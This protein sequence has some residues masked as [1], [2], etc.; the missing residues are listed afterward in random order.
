VTPKRIII[1]G[2]GA[3]GLAAAIE[4]AH[5][6][7]EVRVLE[8]AS[9]PGGKMRRVNCANR[10]VDAGPTVFTMRWVFDDLLE[11]AGGQLADALPI[12]AATNLARHFWMDGSQLDLHQDVERNIAAVALFADTENADGFSRFQRQAAKH[13]RVLK[14]SFMTAQ[15][16]N[17]LS[18]AANVGWRNLPALLSTRPD[19][20]LWSALGT[21]F[22]DARLRQLYGRYATYVGSSPFD[23]PATLMLIAHVEQ[24][25][26]WQLKGGM[27]S[28]AQTLADTG[29][30]LG[31]QFR[32][33][34]S[35]ATINSQ[36]KRVTGVTLGSGET[37]AA[38]AVVFN[39]DVNALAAGALG[40]DV[41]H[42]FKPRPFGK[43]GLS[44]VT[45]CM[46]AE[47][48]G[49]DLAYHNVFFSDAYEDEFKAIFTDGQLPEQ[50][51]VYICAQDR[52]NG[53][54][55]SGPE[56]LLILINA[57]A[58]ADPLTWD[59][60]VIARAWTQTQRVLAHCGLSI[61][62]VSGSEIATTPADFDGLFPHS[63]G[64]LYGS[65]S[66]GPWSSFTRAGARTQM[67][68][69]YLAGGTVH[70]GPGVP[71]AALSGKLAAQALQADL[72]A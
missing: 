13:Y 72:Y 45:W 35:V 36:Q 46:L 63:D 32:Y 60:A 69:L 39:G 34:T 54:I 17:P 21:Y 53:A 51:T 68:G 15:K 3:G 65:A 22:S 57:P 18:L 70:P 6:G 19:Q 43:R 4:L 11:R 14:D 20:T 61:N 10:G 1:I 27:Q 16:P 55:P 38:D 48:S 58:Q 28:L 7:H 8:R 24:T 40:P 56:R 44:A 33:D 49:V 50:P 31:A 41:Q 12:V 66:R 26:V 5:Q 64:S 30:R 23:C 25:G 29:V 67:Q 59:A 52:I 37:L 47:V 71:M 2:A 62:P 9:A 42:L